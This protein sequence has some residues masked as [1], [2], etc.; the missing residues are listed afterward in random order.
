MRFCAV[1]DLGSIR[2]YHLVAGLLASWSVTAGTSLNAQDASGLY[3][4][5]DTGVVYRKE[6][7]TIE[8]PVVETQMRTQE[9][10]VYRPETVVSTR[11]EVRTVYTPVVS[12]NWEPRLAN[13]WNPFV[14]PT[15]V[16]QHTPRTHWESRSET[17][18]RQETRTNWVAETRKVDVPQQVVRFQREE[19]TDYVPVGKVAPQHATPPNS[20]E[21]AIASRLRPLD[22]NTRVEPLYGSSQLASGTSSSGPYQG[23]MRANELY[24]STTVYG[25]PLPPVSTGTGIAGLPLPTVWR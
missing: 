24:P 15:V 12:Y 9:S 17:I 25:T 7:R 11:P 4:N 21:S 5:P 16:Y 8:R 3:T 10:T 23:G 20:A 13:R 14:Q 18:E 19:K 2:T 6:Q 1:S 22:A